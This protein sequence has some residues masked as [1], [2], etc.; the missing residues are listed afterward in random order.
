MIEEEI[1]MDAEI[2]DAFESE[3]QSNQNVQESSYD[4]S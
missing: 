1:M 4:D 3:N 2:D